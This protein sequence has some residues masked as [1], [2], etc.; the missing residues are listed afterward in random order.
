MTAACLAA[1]SRRLLRRFRKAESGNVIFL[2]AFGLIPLLALL[3]GALDYSRAAAVRTEMQVAADNAVLMLARDKPGTLTPAQITAKGQKYFGAAFTSSDVSGLAVSTSYSTTAGLQ[4]AM[5]ASA[6]V[7]TKIMSVVGLRQIQIRVV[8]TSTWGNNRLRVALVLDN[9][10]SMTSS[11]KM[12]ALQGA[13]TNLLGQL[14]AAVSQPGDVYVS[15]IPFSMPVNVDKANVGASWVRWD[16]WD[17]TNG[18]TNGSCSTSSFTTRSTCTAKNT[19]GKAC[20][21]AQ[22]GSQ[23]QCTASGGTW[24]NYCSNRTYTTQSTC[25]AGASPAWTV[26]HATW[27]GC[28]TDRDQDNDTTDV[29]P[30]AGVA[31]T[32]FPADPQITYCPASLMALSN[33]W[34][35]LNAKVGAMVAVGGTNQTIGLQWG[36][37]SLLAGSP[38]A[39]PAK[40]PNYTYS[41]IIILLS[42]GLN[43]YDRW[44]GNGTSGQSASVIA[45]I[46]A[47]MAKACANAKADAITIYTIQVNTDGDPTS[48]VLQNCASPDKFSI[49]T[50]ASEIAATFEKIGSDLTAL[51]LSQ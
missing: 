42:D 47:R 16:L 27:N 34:T 25:L 17:A 19:W 10:G 38:L 46:D 36:Y 49:L 9:T 24:S 14:Q 4:V 1:R 31:S 11:G 13:T 18:E 40:D 8:S 21:K 43:T 48:T 50:S 28:V 32:L 5:T 3:G 2:F 12:T 22:Y 39:V 23:S 26:S 37:Q 7:N 33:D 6:S 20:S 30:S 45:K 41:N 51:R 15:I 29:V 44:Y 35:A